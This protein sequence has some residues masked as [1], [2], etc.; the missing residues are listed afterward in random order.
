MVDAKLTTAE[1][2]KL[3]IITDGIAGKITNEQAAKQLGLSIRQ[4]QRAKAAIRKGGTAAIIHQLKGKS[5]NHRYPQEDKEKVIATI[6]KRYADFKPGFATEKLQET[7]NIPM[8]S[9][10]VRIWMSEAGLWKSRKQKKVTYRALRPRKAYFGELQQ[11]D[12]SYHM[13]FENRYCD[14]NGNPIETCLLASIDDATGKITKAYFGANE[15]VVAVFS[16]WKEYVE[17]V[18][19]PVAIYLDKFSTYKINH[20]AAVD[21]TELMTQFQRAMK[22]L[23]TELISANSPQAKGRVE[24]LFQ[25]LQDRLVKEMRLAHINT[26][27]EGNIFLKKLFLP[28]WNNSKFVVDPAKE[29]DV[30]KKLQTE[31][32]ENLSHI[33]SIHDTRRINF[34]FTIQFKNNWYQ[35]T[36]IQPI[37][38]RPLMIVVMETWLDESIHIMLKDHELAFTLLPEKPKKQRIKQ[39]I[40]LTTH[41]LCQVPICLDKRPKASFLI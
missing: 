13:W 8:T 12:G 15:G 40:I 38:V 27:R 20:K 2:E 41:T 28:Q 31:E 21:N 22:A 10:T 33:F 16:F 29:G 32:K 3:A 35:L 4:V 39:P 23:A 18:G 11:F 24:R 17:K 26:P 5:S 37:T 36:E 25:T 7:E 14:S 9:Q 6:K 34:D 19:K 30:H 1:H